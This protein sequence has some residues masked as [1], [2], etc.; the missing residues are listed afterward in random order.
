MLFCGEVGGG[1]ML[2]YVWCFP[3]TFLICRFVTIKY[4]KKIC[5]PYLAFAHHEHKSSR[6][7]TLTFKANKERDVGIEL[8]CAAVSV[9]AKL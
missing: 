7:V 3:F 5:S 4:K 8:N 9:S 2:K 1:D 6:Y